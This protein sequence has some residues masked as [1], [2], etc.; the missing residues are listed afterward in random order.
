MST[1]QYRR[2]SEKLLMALVLIVED[3]PTHRT[4]L[5][6]ALTNDTAIEFIEAEDG[7]QALAVIQA[8]R[9]D[10]VILDVNIP[11]L[12]GLEVCRRLKA[13]PAFRII[14]IVIVGADPHKA[15]ARRRR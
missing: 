1:I 9:P 10:L 7:L 8:Q 6:E 15:E 13:D 4:L 14:P 12:D 3:E 11:S 2:Q 5:R